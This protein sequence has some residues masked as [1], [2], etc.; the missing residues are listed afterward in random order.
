MLN[1]QDEDLIFPSN[2]VKILLSTFISFLYFIMFFIVYFVFCFFV[3]KYEWVV[4]LV[5]YDFDR[6]W[7]LLVDYNAQDYIY[8]F[9]IIEDKQ[10][11]KSDRVDISWFLWVLTLVLMAFNG[12]VYNAFVHQGVFRLF[13][14]SLGLYGLIGQK[15]KKMRYWTVSEHQN[16]SNCWRTL[17]WCIELKFGYK[18]T[19]LIIFNSE[20]IWGHLDQRVGKVH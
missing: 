17:C 19:T 16:F 14:V 12:V 20:V 15:C 11:L 9:L 13:L 1:I 4:S 18:I 5:D 6:L 7:W 2:L 8:M 3:L 10:R